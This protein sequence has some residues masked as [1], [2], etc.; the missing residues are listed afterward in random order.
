MNWSFFL[1]LLVKLLLNIFS[2]VGTTFRLDIRYT[3]NSY[4]N[5][6]IF[7]RGR[8]QGLPDLR[9][10]INIQSLRLNMLISSVKYNNIDIYFDKNL[11]IQV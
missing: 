4:G 6:K 3:E 2:N 8:S 9:S 11:S 7:T 10:R 5:Y 1:L